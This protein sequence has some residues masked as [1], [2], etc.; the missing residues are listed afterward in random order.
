[1]MFRS[2]FVGSLKALDMHLKIWGFGLS[3]NYI[4]AVVVVVVAADTGGGVG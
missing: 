2:L 3:S 1:M 4:R